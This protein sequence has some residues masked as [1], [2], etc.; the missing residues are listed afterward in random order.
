[1]KK[2]K[3]ILATMLS[4]C[5]VLSG[6]VMLSSCEE[7]EFTSMIPGFNAFA[8]KVEELTHIH[9]IVPVEQVDP[10]CNEAGTKAYYACKG[11]DEIYADEKGEMVI[12]APDLIEKLSHAYDDDY[13]VDCNLCGEV[14]VAKCRHASTEI[15]PKKDA[16]CTES[17][18]TAGEKCNDCGETITAQDTIPALDHLYDNDTDTTCNRTGC[19]YERCLHTATEA[20][21]AATE[22]TCTKQGMTAGEKCSDCG[23]ILVAQEKLPLKAHT[24]VATEA[25]AAG[26]IKTGLTAGTECYVCGEAIKAQETVAATGHKWN[27]TSC[28]A[29]GAVKF[30]AENA[31]LVTDIERAGQGLQ[32]NKTLEQANYPSGGGYVYYLSDDGNATLTFTVN[33]SKAGKAVLSFCMG[34]SYE[35]KA[36]QLF[37]LTVNGNTF[38][39]YPTAIFPDYSDAGV[40]RYFGWYEVEVAEVDLVEGSNTIVLTRNTKGINFDYIALRSTDGAVIGNADCAADGHNYGE[41]T[42]TTTP[43]Y[44]AAGEIKKI[45]S[46]CSDTQTATI[47]AVSAEN[48]YTLVSEGTA[49]VWEYAHDGAKITV[50]IASTSESVKY[51]FVAGTETDPFIA[52]N[53]GSTTSTLKTEEGVG[54]YYG[55]GTN[56]TFTYTVKVNATEASTVTLLIRC[57]KR[58]G[59]YGHSDIFGSLTVNNSTDGVT[60]TG[61]T[62][63]WGTTSAA[64]GD[65]KDY[66]LATISLTKGINTIEFTVITSCNV[67]AVI[68]ESVVPVELGAKE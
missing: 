41:W 6:V 8:D 66:A 9:R 54:T 64:W 36:S 15:L 1:M 24:E 47:P 42:V 55:N 44:E 7:N 38:E 16:T 63:Q 61:D 62:I 13:D 20:A 52:A 17:G 43:T 33:S 56:K 46:A 19:G 11:C 51:T 10:T 23:E 57:A 68:I 35:Y 4:V 3:R 53:D 39:Y 18:L 21:G 27:G 59:P 37:A 34:L 45:C 32:S 30:E 2:M 58:Y 5:V 65:F 22:S 12:T 25:V 60:Y 31:V 40:T 49:S 67:E 28:T 14:R 29:C 26:C 50:S 48:G